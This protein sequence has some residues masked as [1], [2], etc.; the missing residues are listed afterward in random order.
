ME[1][2]S[3]PFAKHPAR[4]GNRGMRPWKAL[5]TVRRGEFEKPDYQFISAPCFAD[6]TPILEGRVQE[7]Q[8]Q[9]GVW[10]HCAEVCDLHSMTSRVRLEPGLRLVMVLA[11]E[12]DVSIGGRRL[13]LRAEEASAALVS[14]SETALFERRWRQGKWE[15]KVSLH[16]TSQ[17]LREHATV[18][19]Q[20]REASLHPFGEA[21]PLAPAGPDD[22][23]VR[24]WTPSAHAVALAEQLILDADSNASG[25]LRLKQAA[26]AL[27]LL[28]EAVVQC[29]SPCAGVAQTAALRWRSHERMLRVRAFLD[30]EI[31]QG[32]TA[33]L[34]VAA[35]GR[36]FGLS[37]SALQR[38]FRQAFAVSITEY[39]RNM[40]LMQARSDL[41]HGS[42]ISEVADRA[43]Y[44]SAAN[45]STAF[46][47][48]FGVTPSE[49]QGRG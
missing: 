28:H 32:H 6:D 22:L 10:L 18:C 16:F 12:L 38:Q 17:W 45:F 26:R 21:L 25:L 2:N 24:N 37:A 36:R 40:R 35:L 4:T 41:E 7:V 19:A 29:G 23:C 49:L 8:L 3:D 15:R 31:A 14:M 20:S 27:D 9:P 48:H 43:G 42:R 46:R 33:A 30:E 1:F 39:R 47:R 5:G 13:L 34:G 11:G 44:T